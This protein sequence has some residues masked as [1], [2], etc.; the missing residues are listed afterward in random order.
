M[1]RKYISRIMEMEYPFEFGRKMICPHCRE[2]ISWVKGYMG[3]AAGPKVP[4]L[5][6]S[7]YL[8]SMVFVCPR[9][10]TIMNI[11]QVGSGTNIFGMGD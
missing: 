3:K 5:G 11:Q 9:C 10:E 4:F 6:A 2:E 7:S 8:Y 1:F